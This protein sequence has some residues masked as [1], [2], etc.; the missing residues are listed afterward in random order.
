[1]HCVGFA[2]CVCYKA[3]VG[4]PESFF[5]VFVACLHGVYLLGVQYSIQYACL[6]ALNLS[7]KKYD[8]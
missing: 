2:F 1:V 8:G 6:G 4:L 3:Y 5:N 7:V